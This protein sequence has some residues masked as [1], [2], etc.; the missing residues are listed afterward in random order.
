[1]SIIEVWGEDP[2]PT[3]PA[4]EEVCP[5][6]CDPSH[7]VWTLLEEVKVRSD[8]ELRSDG[9][10]VLGPRQTP[11]FGNWADPIER[12]PVLEFSCD[13]CGYGMGFALS[14]WTQAETD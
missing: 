9:T 2:R 6:G 1:M 3:R 13:E 4:R 14:E 12:P 8:V 5:T 10:F 11:A 7:A